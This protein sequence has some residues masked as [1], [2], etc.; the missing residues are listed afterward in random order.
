MASE[1]CTHLHR[2]SVLHSA[3]GGGC[4]HAGLSKSMLFTQEETI[5]HHTAH[6]NPAWHAGNG[7]S[8]PLP[9]LAAMPRTPLCCRP[10]TCLFYTM[11]NADNDCLQL[12]YAA[13]D[14]RTLPTFQTVSAIL[15]AP[16]C[17]FHAAMV[18]LVLENLDRDAVRQQHNRSL[19]LVFAVGCIQPRHDADR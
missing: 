7:V 9:F 5:R 10:I 16:S 8:S 4:M 19:L 11:P 6:N 15:S 17:R 1:N 12:F 2:S 18:A 3:A 13:S 14:S